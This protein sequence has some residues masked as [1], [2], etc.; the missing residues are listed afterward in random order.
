MHKLLLL[1]QSKLPSV[2]SGIKYRD[3]SRPSSPADNNAA[4]NDSNAKVPENSTG[5]FQVC[6]YKSFTIKS[7]SR[8]D[9]SLKAQIEAL[10][11]KTKKIEHFVLQ[12]DQNFER[13][14]QNQ[15]V[16]LGRISRAARTRP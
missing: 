2:L 5:K 1:N 16:L 15:R 7:Y 11:K 12:V 3:C 10:A 4:Q 14:S 13:M 6:I 9:F 8:A